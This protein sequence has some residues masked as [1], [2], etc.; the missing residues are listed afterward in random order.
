MIIN[1][2]KFT[3]KTGFIFYLSFWRFSEAHV[4]GWINGLH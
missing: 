4:G 1:L 2:A 3:G